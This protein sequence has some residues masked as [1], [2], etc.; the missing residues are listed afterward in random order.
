MLS[1]KSFSPDTEVIV[2]DGQCEI[3]PEL[4]TRIQAIWD[5]EQDRRGDALFNGRMF[6]VQ[7]MTAQRIEGFFV[8]Y[9]LLIAQRLQ[10]D[11]YDSLGVRPLAVSGLLSCPD[12]I[13]FG[14]R[15]AAMTQDANVWELAGSG[16]VDPS[17]VTD[18]GGIDLIARLYDEIGEEIGIGKDHLHDPEPFCLIEDPDSH[19]FEIAIAVT[20]PLDAAA[21]TGKFLENRTEEYATLDIV[22]VSDIGKFLNIHHGNMSEASLTLLK[23]RGLL[24]G[25][26]L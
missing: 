4:E 11:L 23:E 14:C 22:T 7:T 20:T 16:G 12:G 8:D 19:V 25:I 6:S 2:T 13:V 18:A 3:T 21:I 9:R 5:A 15:G 1:V 24:E 26:G 10:P 17:A